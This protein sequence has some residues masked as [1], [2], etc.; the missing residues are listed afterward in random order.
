MKAKYGGHLI[1]LFLYI[2]ESCDLIGP[3]SVDISDNGL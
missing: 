3:S 2:T 1:V